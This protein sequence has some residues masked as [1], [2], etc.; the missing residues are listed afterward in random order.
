MQCG[1]REGQTAFVA[2]NALPFPGDGS[3]WLLGGV[4]LS[5]VMLGP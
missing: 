4:A 3:A 5:A 2:I 1:S